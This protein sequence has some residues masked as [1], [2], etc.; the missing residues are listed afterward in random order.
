VNTVASHF[1]SFSKALGLDNAPAGQK[2]DMKMAFFG[3]ATSMLTL[4]TMMATES[5]DNDDVGATRIAKLHAEMRE[6]AK[7]LQAVAR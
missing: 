3:G 7:S 6:F 4:M 2:H 5:G 1:A